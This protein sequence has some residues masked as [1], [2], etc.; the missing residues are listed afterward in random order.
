MSACPRYTTDRNTLNLR[1]MTFS[2]RLWGIPTY[3]LGT[4]PRC[5]WVEFG[6]REK[7]NNPKFLVKLLT[8]QANE[9]LGTY[10]DIRTCLALRIL[11]KLRLLRV[12]GRV[13]Y[14]SVFTANWLTPSKARRSYHP[15]SRVTRELYLG[16]TG[17]LY[18]ERATTY[19]RRKLGVQRLRRRFQYSQAVLKT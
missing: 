16:P 8:K 10:L 1:R 9:T 11:F 15:F 17:R 6:N 14:V 13:V 18:L 7:L 5:D 3:K 19:V 12:V 2:E 4:S